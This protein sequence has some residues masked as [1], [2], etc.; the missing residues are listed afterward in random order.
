MRMLCA[1]L[2][3]LVATAGAQ[4]DDLANILG[5]MAK[6]YAGK[7]AIAFKHLPSGE[8]YFL[9]ADEPM[10]TASLIKLPVLV[11]TYYQV[12]EGKVKLSDQITLRKEDMV[13]GS[14]VLTAHFSPGVTFPLSDA[15]SLMIA[16][17][18]NTATNLV[19]DKI[20]VASTGKRM[21]SLGFPN[22]SIYAK[23]FK[24]S[25]TSIDMEKSKKFGL[26][27]TTAREMV[28]LLELLNA[29]KLV[30]AASC[31]AMVALLKKCEDIPKFPRYLPG[32]PVAHKTGQTDDVRTDA[33]LIY[34]K[35]GTV[36]LCV[37]TADNKDT[38]WVVDNAGNVL[39]AD[40]AKAVA[41]Y[42]NAKYKAAP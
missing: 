10:S 17:S 35:G 24:R 31:K 21:A 36:A 18:D 3:V 28:G 40:V 33:G 12:H 32:T 39:C 6:K 37:L 27:S 15:L 22:T 41:D 7:V 19:L 1:C 13:P 2:T 26:G 11:E 34:L 38:R 29:N 30:D 8:T 23:V 20:G 42:C 14:G 4:A 25:T 9:N 16:H 5:P